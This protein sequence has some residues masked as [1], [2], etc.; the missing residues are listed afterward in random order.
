MRTLKV[1]VTDSSKEVCR[2]LSHIINQ[3]VNMQVVGVANS[4]FEARTLIK[5]LQPDVLTLAVEFPKMN[6]LDFL[7]KIMTLR[8]MPVIVIS[9]LANKDSIICQ[10]AYKRGA[11]ACIHK[12]NMNQFDQITPDL[13][14][15]VIG[16]SQK[17]FKKAPVSS[18]NTANNKLESDKYIIAIGAST[19]GTEAIT[20]L[21]KD[22]PLNCPG[23]V[24]TQHMPKGFTASF[25]ARLDTLC[26]I[27]VCEAKHNEL[28]KPGH[29]YIAPG[30]T[31]LEVQKKSGLYYTFLS[32]AEPINLH[33]PSIDHLFNS[34]ANCAKTT[35][36]GVLLTG[37]GKDGAKGLLEMKNNGAKTFAQDEV[38]SIVYGMPKEAMNIG[39][40]N[41]QLAL[42]DIV[43]ALLQ[44][45]KGD[46]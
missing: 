10:Q 23:I 19:G 1:L 39:A 46:S 2:L 21:L 27:K 14:Q 32:D 18:I 35:G 30:D 28:I 31:H 8:P 6:G 11:F 25:A 44:Y 34:M 3:Q 9:K 13:I 41:H 38:T 22:M 29:V 37:M 5:K 40:V 7:E 17:T 45:I 24:I 16:A 43:P 26:S 12:P 20:E 36:V 33:K 42:H 15:A 4:P